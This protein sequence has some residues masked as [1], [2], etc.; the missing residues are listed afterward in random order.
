MLLLVYPTPGCDDNNGRSWGF[1]GPFPWLPLSITEAATD[2]A[3]LRLSVSAKWRSQ[4][5]AWVGGLLPSSPVPSLPSTGT[6]RQ[7]WA[8]S[9]P[10]TGGGVWL[11][12]Q[13]LL[14]KQ[15]FPISSKEKV[16][17]HMEA[18]CGPDS[19]DGRQLD[20]AGLDQNTS[21]SHLGVCYFLHTEYFKLGGEQTG[22]NIFR[23]RYRCYFSL[24]IHFLISRFEFILCSE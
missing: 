10:D 9:Q 20:R 22:Q 17:G 4:V 1:V 11:F 21:T 18:S 13:H 5:L 8:W 3:G 12:G 7:L 15:L 16:A 2:I 23:F 14:L 6:R 24:D 19:A